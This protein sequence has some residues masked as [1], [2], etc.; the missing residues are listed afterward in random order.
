MSLVTTLESR[1]NTGM[2]YHRLHQHVNTARVKEKHSFNLLSKT[3]MR[4]MEMLM[5]GSISLGGNVGEMGISL[6]VE[7]LACGGL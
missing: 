5:A 1:D 4:K 6:A 3:K 2:L 7:E